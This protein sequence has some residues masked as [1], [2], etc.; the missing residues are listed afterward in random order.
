MG[1]DIRECK[2]TLLAHFLFRGGEA[3]RPEDGWREIFGNPRITPAMV[4]EVKVLVD[5]LGV[6]RE[7]A[8]RMRR[9]RRRAL[10]RIAELPPGKPV[11]ARSGR[12]RRVQRRPP[13]VTEGPAG[14]PIL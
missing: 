8:A 11:A 3:L 14:G 13:E 7:M 5:T 1:S 2:Q 4:D 9:L 12:A 10:D 6:R